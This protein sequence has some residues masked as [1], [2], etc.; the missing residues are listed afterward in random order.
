[1][2]DQTHS[3]RMALTKCILQ[4]SKT[5]CSNNKCSRCSKGVECSELCSYLQCRNHS[6]TNDTTDEGKLLQS[7][8][9][10]AMRYLIWT[11]NRY[12]SLKVRTM[13]QRKTTV[14][15]GV[16]VSSDPL[17]ADDVMFTL[18]C[19]FPS[20]M[21]TLIAYLYSFMCSKTNSK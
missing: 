14:A 21:D 16:S 9:D 7:S 17:C 13:I 11:M 12:L 4:L 15:T 6:N 2:D 8:P 18:T 19:I 1:M 5:A 10:Q 20:Y 3:P